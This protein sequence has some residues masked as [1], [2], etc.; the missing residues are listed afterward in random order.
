MPIQCVLFDSD[1]TLVDSE[2][3]CFRAMVEKFV[4]LG[5]SLDEAELV[6]D[7]RGWKLAESLV[8]LCLELDVSLPEGFEQD[9]RS[10]VAE[11]FESDL[12]AVAGVPELLGQLPCARAVVSSGPLAKM[13]A[14]LRVTGLAQFFGDDLYSSYEVGIW[15]PDPGI[16]LHA[17]RDMGHTPA[18]CIVVEDS[19]IGVAAA[20]AAGIRTY[21]LNRYNDEVAHDNVTSIRCMSELIP[22]FKS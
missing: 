5:A 2:H 1:G 3:L 9:Y 8:R 11:L 22:L 18:D 10:R 17:A 6:R 16:Y 21:F 20:A 4:P 15:K 7:Y 14:A 19:P 12:L 13:R